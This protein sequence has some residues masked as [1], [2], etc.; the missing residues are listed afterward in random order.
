MLKNSYVLSQNIILIFKRTRVTMSLIC[1]SFFWIRATKTVLKQTEHTAGGKQSMSWGKR[2]GQ[3]QKPQQ[4]AN[5]LDQYKP[6]A[7]LAYR[8]K[9]ADKDTAPSGVQAQLISEPHR[10][11]SDA[12]NSSYLLVPSQVFGIIGENIARHR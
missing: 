11:Y 10:S 4:T 5:C 12:N 9:I 6:W 8:A 3:W 1:L 7:P 2:F